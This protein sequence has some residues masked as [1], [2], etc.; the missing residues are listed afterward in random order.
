MNDEWLWWMNKWDDE[1]WYDEWWMM[2]II[3]DDEWLM[4]EWWC[5]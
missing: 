5:E 1:W 2:I 3:N 4:N